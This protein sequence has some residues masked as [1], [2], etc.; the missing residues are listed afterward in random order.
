MPC[1]GT[2]FLLLVHL[3]Q[4]QCDGVFV[5]LSIV[6]YFVM[7]C[8]DLYETYCFLMRVIK[9]VDLDGREGGEELGGAERG[10]SVIRLYCMRK[11]STF[12]KKTGERKPQCLV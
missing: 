8:C 9:K 1:L 6:F 3:V 5:C 4:L 10:K 7:V 11:E 12:I 2:L